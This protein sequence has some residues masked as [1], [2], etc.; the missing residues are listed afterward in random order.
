[1][2]GRKDGQTD[3]PEFEFTRSSLG[4]DLKI[5]FESQFLLG[6]PLTTMQENIYLIL[7]L[8][9]MLYIVYIIQET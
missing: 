1:M 2:D 8:W 9:H 3:T 6:M 4:D 7:Q 5:E